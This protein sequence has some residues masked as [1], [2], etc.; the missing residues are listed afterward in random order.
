[1][2]DSPSVLDKRELRLRRISAGLNQDELASLTGLDPSYISHL[3][4][5][6]RKKPSARTLK[7]IA[8]ALGCDIADLMPRGNRRRP[9]VPRAAAVRASAEPEVK[10]AL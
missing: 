10:A 7:V 5:G 1:M 6:A 8:D 9:R 2:S 4:R 3:E